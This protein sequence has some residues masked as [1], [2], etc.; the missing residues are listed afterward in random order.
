MARGKRAVEAYQR[1]LETGKTLDGRVKISLI[2]QDRVGKTSLG[3]ALKGEQF[4]PNEKSTDG[5]QMHKPLTYADLQP[6]KNS[7]MEEETTT[8][9]HRCAAFISRELLT[10]SAGGQQTHELRDFVNVEP[11][12]GPSTQA[13]YAEAGITTNIKTGFQQFLRLNVLATLKE[14]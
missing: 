3:K 8:Y 11:N 4:N 13:I 2:G 6:W 1:A 7:I 14:T 5:V 10:E 9:H 12:N